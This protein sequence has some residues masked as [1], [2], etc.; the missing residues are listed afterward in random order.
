MNL[1]GL[2]LVVV[3]TFLAVIFSCNEDSCPKISPYFSVVGINNFVINTQTQQQ[4][5]SSNPTVWNEVGFLT[6][7]KI[8]GLAQKARSMNGTLMAFGC[9]PVG[10]LGS[11]IGIL[12]LEIFSNSNYATSVKIGDSA[13]RL[14]RV[15]VMGEMF[16]IAE[17]N[18]IFQENYNF[19]DFKL[20]LLEAP[21]IGGELQSFDIRLKFANGTLFETLTAQIR[22]VK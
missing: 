9:P 7:L 10:Y 4:I 13:S 21:E 5:T 14:F 22:I 19:R 1:K 11:E 12:E 6:E 18:L 8:M 2:G 15:E 3:F 17:F 16:T 20:L